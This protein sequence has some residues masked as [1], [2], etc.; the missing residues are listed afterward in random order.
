MNWTKSNITAV[1]L[2]LAD[3]NLFASRALFRISKV[4]LTDKVATASVSLSERPV[5]YINTSFLNEHITSDDDLKTVLLHEFLHIMLAH[6]TKYKKMNL[7]R[8]I[9][10]DAIINSIIHRIY[11][12]RFS[13]LF[14]RFYKPEGFQALLRPLTLDVLQHPYSLPA[15]IFQINSRIYK[16]EFTADDI[17][18]LIN[19]LKKDYVKSIKIVFI[20]SHDL[21]CDEISEENKQ[22][23][24][25]IFSNIDGAVFNGTGYDNAISAEKVRT[26]AGRMAKIK[27]I[28]WQKATLPLLKRCLE[29]DRRKNFDA[30]KNSM[31]P[32]LMSYDRKAF[33][34]SMNS[35]FLPF[36]HFKSEG[37]EEKRNTIVYLDISGSM[38]N[39]IPE[40]VT[41]LNC[42]RSEIN[43]PIW[44]FSDTVS[45]LKLKDRVL[46]TPTRGG[47]VIQHVFDHMRSRKFKRAIIITDGFVGSITESMLTGLN[48]DNIRILISEDGYAAYFKSAGFKY[49]HLKNITS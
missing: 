47:T 24:N 1:M 19:Y 18:E 38:D 34:M 21:A 42:F 4:E 39:M 32:Y 5:L 31:V 11:G 26:E 28:A 13:D 3:E 35:D 36:S 29:I 49:T 43:Y 46:T 30:V 33:A 20:G 8:N 17:Y 2:D 48:R 45:E 40:L 27:L 14:T 7:L 23:L 10:L 41:L 37:P 15:N 12:S 6:T 16:G 44:G 22:L 9:A 25:D